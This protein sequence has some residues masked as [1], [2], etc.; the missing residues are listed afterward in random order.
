M[1]F[2]NINDKACGCFVRDT[3]PFQI[4]CFSLNIEHVAY[5]TLSSQFD[6]K[7]VTYLIAWNLN[8]LHGRVITLLP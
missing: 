4:F 7:N 8:V 3:R 6:L 1:S 2:L 5:V